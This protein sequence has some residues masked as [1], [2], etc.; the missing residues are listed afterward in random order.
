MA[1]SV[2]YVAPSCQTTLSSNVEETLHLSRVFVPQ[3]DGDSKSH[4]AE[5]L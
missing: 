1:W 5:D 4:E 3:D 2:K